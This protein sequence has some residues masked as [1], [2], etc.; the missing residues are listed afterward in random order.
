MLSASRRFTQ[1]KLAVPKDGISARRAAER[2]FCT[3]R[4]IERLCRLGRILGARKHP[5]T[6]KWWIYPPGIVLE[7]QGAWV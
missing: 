7:A 1:V 4:Q 2:L 6:K 3:P 5:L